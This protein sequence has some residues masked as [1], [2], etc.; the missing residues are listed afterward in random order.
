MKMIPCLV[1]SI[2]ILELVAV[3]VVTLSGLLNKA[4]PAPGLVGA[5][6]SSEAENT[7]TIG[8]AREGQGAIGQAQLVLYYE[9]TSSATYGDVA[10]H[11]DVGGE[12]VLG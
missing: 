4:W 1:P 3:K 7:L 12:D 5:G 8:V 9:A 6:I 10:S 11:G 2:L